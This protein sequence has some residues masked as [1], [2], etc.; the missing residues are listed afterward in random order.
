MTIRPEVDIPKLIH[1][2]AWMM[3][4]LHAA[5]ALDLPDWWIGAGFLRNKVWDAIES[6]RPTPTRDVDLV[7]FHAAD[8]IKETDWAYDE[9]MKRDY[10][11]AEWEIRNQARMHY[12]NGFPPFTSTADGISHWVETATCVAV[13]LVAD[14]LRFLY[15]Y[16]MKD[17]CGLIARPTPYFRSAERIDVFLTRVAE[18]QWRERWPNLRVLPH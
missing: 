9:R 15:C 6:K 17:L 13:K 5:Q 16:G 3:H 4:V 12:V 1:D 14:E 2:D 18:K 10:P 11:F 7:Y 8:V